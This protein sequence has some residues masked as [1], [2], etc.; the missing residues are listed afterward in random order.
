[1]KKNLFQSMSLMAPVL[2]LSACSGTKEK[3]TETKPLNIIHIMTDDHS[4]Q[5]ISAYGHALGKLAP[6]PNIDRLAAR[7]VLFRQAFVENS[8][9]TPS[10]ACLM[11]GLY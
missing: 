4:F 6:T 1:M 3:A 5:T 9:S 2:L 7:G 11:T 8:L 10:R